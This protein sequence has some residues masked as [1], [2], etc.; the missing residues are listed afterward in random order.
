MAKT[1]QNAK[2]NLLKLID[3]NFD[4]KT[5]ILTLTTKENIMNRNE[6]NKLFDKFITHLNY[7]VFGLKKEL[8]ST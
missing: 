5:S 7:N 2:W 3:T 1:R 4:D 6:F 8:L